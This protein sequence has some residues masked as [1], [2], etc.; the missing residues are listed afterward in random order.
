MRKVLKSLVINALFSVV[1][2][3]NLL[4]LYGVNKATVN[5]TVK[6]LPENTFAFYLLTFNFRAAVLDS[7]PD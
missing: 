4:V 5:T 6:P 3:K 7:Y 1:F 2:F